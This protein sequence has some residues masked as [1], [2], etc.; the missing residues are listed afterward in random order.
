MINLRP[1][2]SSDISCFNE[3]SGDDWTVFNW[4][5]EIGRP[6]IKEKFLKD[7]ENPELHSYIA[8]ESNQQEVVGHLQIKEMEPGV[9]RFHRFVVSKKEKRRKG[10]GRDILSQALKIAF[11]EF[12]FDL[13]T[14]GVFDINTPA[15]SFC[16]SM[17]FQP[18][19]SKLIDYRFNDNLTHPLNMTLP[20]ENWESN[21]A[22]ERNAEIAPAPRHLST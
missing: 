11:E 6:I 2:Q 5:D 21:K 8:V 20:K 4:L 3:F 9:G 16:E 14:L 10:I 22:C 19:S 12:E 15:I 1:F 7:L 13:M 18:H 17:G